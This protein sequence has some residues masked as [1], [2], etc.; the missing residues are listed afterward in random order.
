MASHNRRGISWELLGLL[1][2]LA[3]ILVGGLIWLASPGASDEVQAP[4]LTTLDP[5]LDLSSGTTEEGRPY[6]GEAGAPVTVYEFADFQCPHCKEFWRSGAEEI[7]RDY[8]APGDAR[9]EWVSVAFS[10]DESTEASKAGVCAGEQGEFWTMHD[11]LFANQGTLAN[12]GSFSRERVLE[13]A[14]QAGLDTISF[15]ACLDDPATA[16]AVRAGERF[17]SE[18]GVNSTPTFLVNDTIVAGAD[19][20][21]LREALDEAI[22]R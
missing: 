9:V 4:E 18:N 6:L 21:A 14:A 20:D 19:V 2:V 5:E 3:I 16:E 7:A 13:M 22:G 12:T 10:G 15:E 17:A 8:V 1:A 11:W